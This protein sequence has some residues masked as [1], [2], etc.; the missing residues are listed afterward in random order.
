MTLNF[1]NNRDVTKAGKMLSLPRAVTWEAGT[2]S[3]PDS[4]DP[5]S[6][7]GKPDCQSSMCARSCERNISTELQTPA[8]QTSSWPHL[9]GGQKPNYFRR[10]L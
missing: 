3:S 8:Q 4:L 10:I 7:C 5:Q 9:R 1:K 2:G 6:S